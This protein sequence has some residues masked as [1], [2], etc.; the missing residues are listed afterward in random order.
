LIDIGDWEWNKWTRLEASQA[1]TGVIGKLK[2]CYEGNDQDWETFDF[3]FGEVSQENHLLTWKGKV[4]GGVLFSGHYTMELEKIDY[5]DDE[6]HKQRPIRRSLAHV[7]SGIALQEIGSKLFAHEQGAQ[8]S[9]RRNDTRSIGDQKR[10]TLLNDERESGYRLQGVQS[11]NEGLFVCLYVIHS[12][13]S[14]GIELISFLQRSNR[15]YVAT[16]RDV[17]PCIGGHSQLNFQI[18]KD[19]LPQ[20]NQKRQEFRRSSSKLSL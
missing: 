6:T 1:K 13:S 4:A 8:G 9:C 17:R 14:V 20:I 18:F 10:E 5:P 7:E 11:L 2:A 15:Y 19:H 3:F 16:R 12:L